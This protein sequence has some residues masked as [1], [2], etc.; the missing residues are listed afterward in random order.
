MTGWQK[1]NTAP[2][3]ETEIL[4]YGY[5]EGELHEMDDEP[6]IYHA[7]LSCGQYCIV[8]VEYYGAYVMRP[9]HWMP[10]PQPPKGEKNV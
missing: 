9:T 8:G 3:D 4:V 10:L 6:K 5:W 2:K 7:Y 1:M